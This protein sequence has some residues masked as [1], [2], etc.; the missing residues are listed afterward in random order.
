VNDVI[1]WVQLTATLGLL[2]VTYWYAKTTKGM[3]DSARQSAFESARATGAAERSAEAARDAATVAQS[4]IRPE[5]IGRQVS[6]APCNEEEEHVA[7]LRVDSTGD[8]VVIQEVRIRRAFRKS[9]EE[10]RR[11]IAVKDAE[12]TVAGPD[13]TLPKRLHHGEHLLLTHPSIQDAHDDPFKRFIIDIK[14]TFSEA[15]GAGATKEL[16]IDSQ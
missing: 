2:Y 5:F 4:Q 1:A 3:A 12:M 16:I 8:A 10:G 14:Y 11:E 9:Y 7:C 6:L 13:S 15:G